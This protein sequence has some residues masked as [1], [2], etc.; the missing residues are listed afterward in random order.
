M[1]MEAIVAAEIINT[2]RD[3]GAKTKGERTLCDSCWDLYKL[4]VDFERRRLARMD[5]VEGL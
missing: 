4:I 3:C 5:G 2:C 1:P